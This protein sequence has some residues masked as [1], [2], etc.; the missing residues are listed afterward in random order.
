MKEKVLT[1]L[2]IVIIFVGILFCGS[3][4]HNYTINAKVYETTGNEVTFEDEAGFLWVWYD[5]KMDYEK[6]EKVKLF[7]NDNLTKWI[8]DDIIKYVKRETHR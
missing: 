2:M 5:V 4:E 6:D 8:E 7:M 3:I 1:G